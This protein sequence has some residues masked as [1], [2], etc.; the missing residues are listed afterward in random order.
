MVQTFMAQVDNP[1]TL[2]T[3]M[4]A[5]FLFCRDLSG[6][7][8]GPSGQDLE[9]LIGFGVFAIAGLYY[10]R[11]NLPSNWTLVRARARRQLARAHRSRFS[12]RGRRARVQDEQT[13]YGKTRDG[14]CCGLC[15]C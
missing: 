10:W 2:V 5:R 1:I 4:Q 15:P 3:L 14:C 11:R 13:K 12:E 8:A 6:K 7:M 9:V